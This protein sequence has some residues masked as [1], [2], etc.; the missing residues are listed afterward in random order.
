MI[1][2]LILPEIKFKPWTAH[3]KINYGAYKTQQRVN[4]WAKMMFAKVTR[5]LKRT[6]RYV[7]SKKQVDLGEESDESDGSEEDGEYNDHEE[8]E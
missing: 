2:Y 3:D 7:S 4:K 5:K 1:D 6:P 8:I